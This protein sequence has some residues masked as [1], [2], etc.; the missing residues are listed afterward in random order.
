MKNLVTLALL[1]LST[2]AIAQY[3]SRLILSNGY[4]PSAKD[5]VKR[6]G[7][8]VV[9]D[10]KNIN[11]TV[12]NLPSHAVNGF[13]MAFSH[14]TI[15]EDKVIKIG[16]LKRGN[17]PGG[18]DTPQ[19]SQNVDWGIVALKAD[20]AHQASFTGYNVKVCVA[21]TGIDPTHPDLAAN[22]VGGVNFTTKGRTV[23]PSR[24]E[25][26]HGHGTHVAGIIAAVN[27]SIGSV[28]AAYNASIFVVKV[29]SDRGSGYLS[30]IADGVMECVHQG[31][32]VI[33]MSL[34]GNG[35]P[36]SDSVMKTA[37][38]TAANAGIKV[39]LA[40]G[41]EGDDIAKKTPAGYS[42]FHDNIISVAAM[43]KNND[44]SYYMA[45][46]SNYG[47]NQGASKTDVTAPGVS[48][49]STWKD[50][51]YNTISGT[52]MAS[53]YAA[54]VVA[55]ELASGG[56]FNL[57]YQNELQGYTDSKIGHGL[58]DAYTTTQF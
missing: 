16:P 40:A 14:L 52:S 18:G 46:W 26:G 57:F 43:G 54:A 6:R 7:G 25:D 36:F 41:N 19:P 24:I 15:E 29:L 23:D 5:E 3:N 39:V 50:G 2:Q 48:I 12:V 10:L 20:H 55:L 53:P 45:S 44:G 32:D 8:S 21:D 9:A 34:G 4:L 17:N 56:S 49:Y 47:L 22:Y 11:A 35:N 31:A 27:N 13:K 42:Q 58:L 33:N 38:M 51:G 37:I 1:F 30:W 28:G